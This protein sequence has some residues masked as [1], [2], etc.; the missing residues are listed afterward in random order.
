[1]EREVS[2]IWLFG[3]NLAAEKTKD[4]SSNASKQIQSSG[5]DTNSKKGNIEPLMH[6]VQVPIIGLGV[7]NLDSNNARHIA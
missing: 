5:S 1:M 7:L 2:P 6:L 4:K 3:A